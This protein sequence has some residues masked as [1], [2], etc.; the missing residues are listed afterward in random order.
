MAM[1]TGLCW[2]CG[3]TTVTPGT[4]V[5][6]FCADCV[7][8]PRCGGSTVI[9][10]TRAR[11]FW[12]RCIGCL[13]GWW[14]EGQQFVDR[15]RRSAEEIQYFTTHV[16]MEATNGRGQE[17]PRRAGPGEWANGDPPD[18]FSADEE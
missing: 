12:V 13:H 3:R 14:I 11:P 4:Q 15:P 9:W 2:G 10:D 17:G 5:Q 16:F 7:R 8:C 18:M 1:A 6:P